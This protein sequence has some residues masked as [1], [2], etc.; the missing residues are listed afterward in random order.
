M[1]PA[2]PNGEL[3][4]SQSSHDPSTAWIHEMF[5]QQQCLPN[6]QQEAFLKQQENF[7][8]RMM[9]AV[10]VRE[11]I[12][13]EFLIDSLAKHVTEFRYDP[14]E[15]VSFAT[16]YGRFEDLF[17]KDAAKL[18]E[19]AKVRLLLR[20]LGVAEH[21]ERYNSYILPKKACDYGFAETVVRLKALFGTAESD[22]Q[23]LPASSVVR[24]AN[25]VL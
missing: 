1:N 6:Q 3:P 15:R 25:L 24:Y 12:V 14:E 10:N 11:S 21:A 13:P 20:K 16:W 18:P 23:P 9:S 8:T 22:I 2:D 19:D 4:P 17:E 5:K 7:L